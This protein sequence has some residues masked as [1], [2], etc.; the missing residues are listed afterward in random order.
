MP[1]LRPAL[2][3]PGLF[4]AG[5]LATYFTSLQNYVASGDT[6][7]FQTVAAI[8]GISHPTGFPAFTLLSWLFAHALPGVDQTARLGVMSSL[9]IVL[10]LLCGYRLA[11][12]LGASPGLAAAALAIVASGNTFWDCAT[13]AEVHSMALTASA[14]ALLAACA[15]RREHAPWMLYGAL[16]ALGLALATH[17]VAIWTLAA[18]AIVILP[19]VRRIAPRQVVPAAACF[20]AG[21]AIYAYLPI[22]SAM[23]VA[24]HLDPA[25]SIGIPPGSAFW[26]YDN[27]ST[28]AGFLRL[29]TGSEFDKSAALLAPFDVNQWPAHAFRIVANAQVE[30]GSLLLLLALAGLF[31]LAA[32]DYVVAAALVVFGVAPAM[33]VL[34][35]GAESSPGRYFL[36][37]FLVLG[38][39][40]AV[41]SSW[42]LKRAP[43][44]A[45]RAGIALLLSVAAVALVTHRDRFFRED[46]G[47]A[48]LRDT[49]VAGTDDRGILLV[50]WPDGPQLAYYADAERSL[51]HRIVIIGYVAEKKP[52]L[53]DWLRRRPV[54]ILKQN[55]PLLPGFRTTER[56]QGVETIVELFAA[57]ALP[58]ANGA[59]NPQVRSL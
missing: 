1:R 7:E 56:Q 19:D 3:V 49:I 38:I 48:M 8:L 51:G 21:I 33:F 4:A 17:A 10:A 16:G 43:A 59:A 41:G 52:Y 39:C 13:R 37:F 44:D 15:W 20:F 32:R 22:R 54:Y 11:T 23:V 14:A 40:A 9:T 12:G 2:A 5:V 53:A 29:T 58:R 36:P 55:V 34:E 30:Y 28:L 6:A 50:P 18:C 26:N 45:R 47:P 35:Y 27:P 25:E 42:L 46:A 31:V 24:Q 57:G